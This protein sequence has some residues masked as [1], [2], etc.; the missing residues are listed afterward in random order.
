M[1]EPFFSNTFITPVF[2]YKDWLL[3]SFSDSGSKDKDYTSAPTLGL[4]P[5]GECSRKQLGGTCY[6]ED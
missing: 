3:E 4:D 6:F 5:M 1:G 2:V